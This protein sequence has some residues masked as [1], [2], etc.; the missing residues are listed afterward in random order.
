MTTA[1]PRVTLPQIPGPGARIGILVIIL[2]FI[3]SMAAIGCAPALA[4]G[5]AAGAAAIAWN[6]QAARTALGTLWA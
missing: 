4:L 6:P 2:G 3:F 5:I 1:F